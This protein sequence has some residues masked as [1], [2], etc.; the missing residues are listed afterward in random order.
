M[1]VTAVILKPGLFKGSCDF[2]R[3]G[4]VRGARGVGVVWPSISKNKADPYL[5]KCTAAVVQQSV[6]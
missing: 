1:K 6:H 4:G 2:R 5:F 3:G